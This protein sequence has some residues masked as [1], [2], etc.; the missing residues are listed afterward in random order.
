MGRVLRSL[1]YLGTPL[2]EGAHL[3][4]VQLLE[5]SMNSKMNS[6]WISVSLAAAVVAI[7]LV[8]TGEAQALSNKISAG[9]SIEPTPSSGSLPC[10]A[11]MP[12]KVAP[13]ALT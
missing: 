13:N 11:Y 1:E 4:A 3:S 9:A 5:K 2:G 12:D 8:Q 7:A 10:K 6:S